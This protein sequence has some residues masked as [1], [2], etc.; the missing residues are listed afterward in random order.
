MTTL[1]RA[2]AALLAVS[3]LLA[4]TA[5]GDLEISDA[6]SRMSPMLVGVA[7]AFLDVTNDSDTD[8]VLLAARVDPS[9]AERIEL[10][11]TFSVDDEADLDAHVGMDDGM[12]DHDAMGGGMD[13]HDAMGDGMDDHDT[14]GGGMAPTPE[15]FAMMGMREVG[16]IDVPAGSTVSLEPGGLHIM[17]IGLA[18]D[19]QPGDTYDLTLVFE[20]AGERTVTVEVREQV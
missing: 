11:E 15:G 2:L 20:A 10:H 12:D 19:L 18:T 1:T 4:C 3:L 6:R 16:S 13:D 17:L 8:D 7:A 9:V 5:E 14:M